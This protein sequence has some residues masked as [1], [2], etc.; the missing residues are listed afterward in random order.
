MLLLFLP[1]YLPLVPRQN[2]YNHTGL[3]FFP[4]YLPD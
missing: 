1:L 4:L 2:Q 3:T